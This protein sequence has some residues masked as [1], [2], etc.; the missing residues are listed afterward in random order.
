M[1][2]KFF[3]YARKSSE[4]EERQVMSIEAQLFEITEWANRENLIIA[5][6]FVESK[7]AKAPGRKEFN[8]MIEKIHAS[9]EPVGILAWHPDRLA[10]NSIDGGQIVYLIDTKKV[11][12]L[13]FP[14]FWFEPTPQGLFMLQVAFSQ[15]KY[16]SDNLSENIKRGIRQKIRRG[17]FLSGKAPAGYVNNP[18]I[19]NI[20]P[21]PLRVKIIQTFFSDFAQGLYNLETARH[22]LSS[23]G[24][25]CTNGNTYTPFMVYRMLTNRTYIGQIERKG[26]VHEAN[27]Q[28]L[29]DKATFE[30]VQKRLQERARP[31]KAKKLHDFAFRGL[32]RCAECGGQI[33]AQFAK[34][35]KYRY[36][37]C[38]KKFGT[39]KQSYLQEGLLLTQIKGE[40][41]KIAIPDV[42]AENMLS[43]IELWQKGE[44]QQTKFLQQNLNAELKQIDAQMD[45]LVNGY[46]EAVIEKE[47]YLRKKDQLLKQKSDLKLKHSD[48]G[49][50]SKSW[51]EP[52]RD[53]VKTL[54]YAGKLAS[55]DADLSAYKALSEKVG[56]NRLLKDKKIVWDWLPPFDL[57]LQDKGFQAGT[58]KSPDLSGL[59]NREE[60]N[61]LLDWRTCFNLARTFFEQK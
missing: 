34:G 44:L 16:Y 6:T 43:E 49:S 23:V 4:A 52:L 1:K 35:G 13:C 58:K 38:S 8:R 9:K 60:K 46:L 3:L 19:R 39:C 10:R 37:R 28:P 2:P 61:K 30:M 5:E 15:S 56:S 57:L 50:D 45:K 33:T 26:E 47:I 14:T 48:F 11:S 12:A 54:N 31:R 41:Q 7:S 27:F 55:M 40:F 42:W 51:L 20:E 53:F 21:D 59:K 22:H 17:E 32:F 36:Y 18:R 29:I 25:V 24:I